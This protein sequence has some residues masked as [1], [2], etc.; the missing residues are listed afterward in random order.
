MPIKII[1]PGKKPGT[2]R[3]RCRCCGC[4]FETD[5]PEVRRTGSTQDYFATC[6]TCNSLCYS[7][8]DKK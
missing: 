7:A 6:P 4:I 8:G 5:T 1:K 2:V 3:F